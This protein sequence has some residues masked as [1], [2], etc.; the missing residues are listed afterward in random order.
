MN[1]VLQKEKKMNIQKPNG[2]NIIKKT[3][4][5]IY[6]ENGGDGVSTM[7]VLMGH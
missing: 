3:D 1:K 4:I 5:E 6:M 2:S 7:S